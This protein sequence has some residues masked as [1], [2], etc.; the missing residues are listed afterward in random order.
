MQDQSYYI[1][2]NRLDGNICDLSKP[3]RVNC[4]G[5]SHKKNY[6]FAVEA[7]RKDYYLKIMDEGALNVG[8]DKRELVRGQF[9]IYPPNKR[10]Y[11]KHKSH[12]FGY[13]W[14][15]FTGN[16]VEQLLSV[17][18]LEPDKIYTLTPATMSW[19][20]LEFR[21]I[22]DEFMLKRKGVSELL[23]ARCTELLVRL[24]RAVN[25]GNVEALRG[26]LEESVRYMHSHYNEKIN[27]SQ[28][29]K[30]ENL[31]VSRF[32]ALFKEAFGKTP[33]EYISDIR[34]DRATHYLSDSNLPIGE[35]ATLCGYPDPLYFSRIFKKKCGISPLDY[36]KTKYK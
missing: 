34:L 21:E 24:S 10:H 6:R 31:C 11:Y 17:C 5:Y 18:E 4:A 20:A 15:H 8:K 29:A 30:I 1:D 25:E 28:L 19:L 26:R 16:A 2:D 35:I 12:E 27:I 13:Y 33:V 36:R 22:Y 23:A 14:I 9:I 3:L 7:V 32:R